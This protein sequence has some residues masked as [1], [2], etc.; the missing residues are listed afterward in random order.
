MDA[1]LVVILAGVAFTLILNTVM[2]FF[3]YKAFGAV[4]T[5]VTEGVHEFQTSAETRQ[6]LTKM[7]S[8]SEQ[9]AKVTGTIKTEIVGFEP[10]IERIQEAHT[11]RLAKADVRFKLAFGAIRFAT[12]KGERMMTW[13]LR[14][15]NAAASGIQ[16]IIDFFRGSEN[17][18]DASSRRNR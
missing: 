1:R 13:P 15:L 2:I 11:K 12:D 4:S 17:G 6:W 18:A 8:T 3:A 10:A 9:L 16:G 14:N 5:K 7:Q